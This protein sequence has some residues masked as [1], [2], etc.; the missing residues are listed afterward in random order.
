MGE[1]LKFT[2]EHVAITFYDGCPV[3]QYQRWR[4]L[5]RVISTDNLDMREPI[6]SMVETKDYLATDLIVRRLQNTLERHVHRRHAKHW[7]Y[8]HLSEFACSRTL[9]AEKWILDTQGRAIMERGLT[10]AGA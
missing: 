7:A 4:C 8:N 6:F 10:P 9:T 5:P 3:P 1:V 2:G